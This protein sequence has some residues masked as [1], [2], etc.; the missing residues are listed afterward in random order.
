MKEINIARTLVNKRKEKCI[1]QEELAKYIGVSKASVS[2]WERGQSYPDITFLPQLAAYFN[3]SIDDL[4]GY[5]PQ[6]SREDICKLYH[7]L[8]TDFTSKP[9]DEVLNNCRDIIKK[10]YACLPLLLQMGVL[11]L[12]HSDLAKDT[13]KTTALTL[14]AK[15]LFIRVKKE[16]GDVELIKQAQ[17]MEAFCYITIRDPQSAMELLEAMNK[18]LLPVEALLASA[19]KMSGKTDEA[20]STLQIGIYQYVIG[21]FSVFPLYLAMCIDEPKRYEEVLNRAL[22]V[23]ETFNVK[24]LLPT[25]IMELYIVAAQGYIVQGNS[26][27]SLNMLQKYTELATSNIYQLTPH[28]DNFFDS[29]DHWLNKLDL[30][31]GMVKNEKTIKQNVVDLVVN[32]PVFSSLADECSFQSMVEKLKAIK[33][34][35]NERGEQ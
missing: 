9:Y 8:S 5:E 18:P 24:Q 2:K 28:G 11:I 3:I 34:E 15:E 32:S 27:K 23:E 14:E 12:F 29:L 21:L 22:A 20:K 7:K 31:A 17:Y 1:T 19:Y 26:E 4:M 35:N 30:G 25:V 10:Y 13:E 33:G 6:M 16:S